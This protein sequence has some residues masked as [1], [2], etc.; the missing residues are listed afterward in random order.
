MGVRAGF[1]V[2]GLLL[3]FKDLGTTEIQNVKVRLLKVKKS[4]QSHID[5]M[6]LTMQGFRV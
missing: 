6:G 5:R 4:S 1:R 2:Q 3:R